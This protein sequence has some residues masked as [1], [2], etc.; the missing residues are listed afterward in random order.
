MNALPEGKDNYLKDLFSDTFFIVSLVLFVVFY[1]LGVFTDFFV[2]FASMPVS[3]LAGELLSTI[4]YSVP[5][6]IGIAWSVFTFRRY[7]LLRKAI[8]Y[9]FSSFL[10]LFFINIFLEAVCYSGH[11]TNSGFAM[12]GF[13][14]I[15]FLAIIP[16]FILTLMALAIFYLTDKS[17]HPERYSKKN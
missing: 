8:A 10:L 3:P 11:T 5:Y 17:K 4:L 6:I 7:K 13:V 15:Q 2:K 9:L 1:A 12:L 16:L 14:Y